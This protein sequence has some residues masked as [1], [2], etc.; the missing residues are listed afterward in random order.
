M[1]RF[2][3]QTALCIALA[4]AVF[5][6]RA[7]ESTNKIGISMVDIP[8]GSFVMGSCK[9]EKKSAFLG[10]SACANPDPDAFENEVPQ[11]TVQVSSFQI[12]KTEVTLKQYSQFLKATG[13]YKRMDDD[14]MKFNVYGD[15]APVVGVTW[16]D[17]QAFILWLNATDGGGWRL[18]S[19][20]EWEY[21]CRAGGQHAHCGGDDL[22]A[23]AWWNDNSSRQQQKVGQKRANAFGLF[24]MSG[25]A[26]EW[27]QDC[28]HDNYLNAPTQ[29][30]PSWQIGCQGGG[31][32][33]RGGSWKDFAKDARSASRY[34]G[35]PTARDYRN[36]F[37]LAR[38]LVGSGAAK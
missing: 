9:L 35:S 38:T 28:W 5:A 33:L 13:D 27:V 36:G 19:E 25:N 1:K 3:R 14:F 23:V 21:A 7:G 8:Q 2:V 11:R 22:D 10:E 37:R 4:A 17:A 12:S 15:D 32:V 26:Q 29:S 24:D 20:A 16:N 34:D 18:P 30:T 6:A 31:R